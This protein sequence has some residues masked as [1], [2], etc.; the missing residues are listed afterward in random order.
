[1]FGQVIFLWAVFDSVWNRQVMCFK[2]KAMS[3]ETCVPRIQRVMGCV[4][5]C[6]GHLWISIWS[7]LTPPVFILFFSS[8]VAWELKCAEKRTGSKG[9]LKTF[10]STWLS[11]E[12]TQVAYTPVWFKPGEA[13]NA[14]TEFG[15]PTWEGQWWNA[16]VL[17]FTA[18]QKQGS[19]DGQE[20]NIGWSQSFQMLH[21]R[22]CAFSKLSSR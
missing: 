5:T 13:I 4:R 12:V 20:E 8:H 15:E 11:P 19:L 1:M 16:R 10:C 22:L 14:L 17:L 21:R 2:N 3:L 9:L 18:V 7:H 6:L